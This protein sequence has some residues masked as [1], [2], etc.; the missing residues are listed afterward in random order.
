MIIL[1]PYR[2]VGLYDHVCLVIMLSTGK[3]RQ[4]REKNEKAIIIR[5]E[6]AC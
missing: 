3:M 1:I 5:T 4:K 2:I 6:T